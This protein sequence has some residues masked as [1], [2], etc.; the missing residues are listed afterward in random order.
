VNE[1]D[2]VTAERPPGIIS[3]WETH[4][5]APWPRLSG[6]DEG[7]LMTLDTV[8]S[9]CVSYYLE[10]DE[11]LDDR[12]AMILESC[13]EDLGAMLPEL[14][15][16]ANEYFSRASRLATMILQSRRP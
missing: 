16:E 13:L 14:S 10:S 11:R 8:I 5:N 7:Q 12:R 2:D 6:Q 15:D 1:A 9:G 3:L 4:R